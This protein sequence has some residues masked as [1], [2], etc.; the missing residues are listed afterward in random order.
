MALLLVGS[1]ASMLI[2]IGVIGLLATSWFY[3]RVMHSA[4][5]EPKFDFLIDLAARLPA[6]ENVTR[7]STGGGPHAR[8]G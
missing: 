2:V 5:S 3:W 8:N 1:G 7:D 4:G 6:D